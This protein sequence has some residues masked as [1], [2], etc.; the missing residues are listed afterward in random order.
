MVKR[1]SWVAV[2]SIRWWRPIANLR[3]FQPPQLRSLGSTVSCTSE[4]TLQGKQGLREKEGVVVAVRLKMAAVVVAELISLKAVEL[5]LLE[6]STKEFLVLNYCFHLNKNFH[7]STNEISS[8]SCDHSNI[9]CHQNILIHLSNFFARYF[10]CNSYCYDHCCCLTC[11]HC[12]VAPT[13]NS[14]AQLNCHCPIC[15]FWL[16]H[17]NHLASFRPCLSFSPSVHRHSPNSLLRGSDR[18][19]ILEHRLKNNHYTIS[20]KKLIK[21]LIYINSILASNKPLKQIFKR[22]LSFFLYIY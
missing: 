9:H 17:H 8:H 10:L 19:E 11:I 13:L 7:S 20:L 18:T 4:R 3:R 12:L 15:S 5:L 1:F 2:G 22:I 21:K 6:K 16:C 14:E